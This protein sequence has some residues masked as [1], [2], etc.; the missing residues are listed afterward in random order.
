[1]SDTKVLVARTTQPLSVQ[2]WGACNMSLASTGRSCAKSK[3]IYINPTYNRLKR[4]ARPLS[5]GYHNQAQLLI[6]QFICA[7]YLIIFTIRY[8]CRIIRLWRQWNKSDGGTGCQRALEH[9]GNIYRKILQKDRQ[10]LG[11]QARLGQGSISAVGHSSP[12]HSGKESRLQSE[13]AQQQA[14]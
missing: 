8:A 10:G 6:L 2:P 5:N 11:C 9:V 7:A 3:H 12:L 13:N 1:M 14:A 4:A